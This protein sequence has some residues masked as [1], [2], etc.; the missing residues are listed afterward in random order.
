MAMTQTTALGAENR[1]F[2]NRTLNFNNIKLLGF[3]MDYTLA[4]YNVPVFEEKAFEI[5]V[6]KLIKGKGYPPEIRSLEFDPNFVIRGLII[7]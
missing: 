7:D 5:V 1:V 2:V 6:E 3:D 4:T